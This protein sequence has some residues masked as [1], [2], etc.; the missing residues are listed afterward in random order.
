[1]PTMRGISAVETRGSA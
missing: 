1:M